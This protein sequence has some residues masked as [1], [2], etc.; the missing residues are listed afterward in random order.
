METAVRDAVDRI[1]SAF[2]EGRLEDYFAC[3]AEDATF[4]F[5]TTPRRL[6]SLA[7]YRELWK[8]WVEE[9][10]FQVLSCETTDTN[11]QL[12]GDVAVVT[13]AVETT[14]STRAGND[15]LHERETIVLARDADRGWVAVHE[16]LSPAP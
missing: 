9:D 1:V 14:I 12:L 4:V 16:H 15:T 13:H 7:D 10:G 11:I 5:Y 2:G 3:F 8:R 6:M